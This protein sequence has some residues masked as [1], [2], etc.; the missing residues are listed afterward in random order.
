M[1]AVNSAAIAQLSFTNARVYIKFKNSMRYIGAY[2]EY[3]RR[4][5]FAQS[6]PTIDPELCHIE[7]FYISYLIF[8]LV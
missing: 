7:F 4:T 5:P 6:R 8:Q 2:Y 3:Y 1:H